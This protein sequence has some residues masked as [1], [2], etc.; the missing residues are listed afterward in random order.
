MKFHVEARRVDAHGSIARCKDAETTLDTDMAGSP[1]AFNPAEGVMIPKSFIHRKRLPHPWLKKN[2]MVLMGHGAGT[3]L[4]A[5]VDT[6]N[7]EHGNM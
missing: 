4:I 6:E 5:I 1:L 3:R 7:R 2:G